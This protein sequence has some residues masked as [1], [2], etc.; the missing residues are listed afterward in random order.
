MDS[1][2]KIKK[3][4]QRLKAEKK[5]LDEP[6]AP[7]ESKT[8]K[9][10][11]KPDKEK[12]SVFVGPK[13]GK[14]I[15]T[16][17]GKRK[18]KGPDAKPSQ[19]D[20]TKKS[21]V[22]TEEKRVEKQISDYDVAMSLDAMLRSAQA[23]S[24]KD[25]M[26]R[27]MEEVQ[28]RKKQ[29]STLM[30]DMAMAKST[31]IKKQV[32]GRLAKAFSEKG[33]T[34]VQ[35]QQVIAVDVLLKSLLKSDEAAQVAAAAGTE[36]VEPPVQ[37]EVKFADNLFKPYALGSVL[38]HTPGGSYMANSRKP[39]QDYVANANKMNNKQYSDADLKAE[40]DASKKK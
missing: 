34:D 19:K 30:K 3:L 25:M 39:N 9:E 18:Y 27:C 29:I 33:I 16:K 2:Q 15:Q 1:K 24:D 12:A 40:I 21:M 5:K 8:K 17:T 20:D 13:G 22:L 36:V 28:K 26:K 35:R 4:V 32:A 23:K 6:K 7:K 11:A 31:E 38:T 37:K 14:Y 10:E